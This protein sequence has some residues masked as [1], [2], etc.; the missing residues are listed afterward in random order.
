VTRQASMAGVGVVP[1]AVV[2]ERSPGILASIL[3]RFPGPTGL[4][5]GIHSQ[6]TTSY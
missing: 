6:L 3:G 4:G 1:V 2:E 5:H